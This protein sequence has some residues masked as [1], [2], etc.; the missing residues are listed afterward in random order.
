MKALKIMF[1]RVGEIDL[2]RNLES[3]NRECENSEVGNTR[4]I[5]SDKRAE[6]AREQI[7]TMFV[8]RYLTYICILVRRI[9]YKKA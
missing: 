3:K 9:T 1:Q 2:I 4:Q 8:L 7:E 6:A 5:E